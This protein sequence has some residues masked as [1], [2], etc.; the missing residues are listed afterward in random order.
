MPLQKPTEEATVKEPVKSS[1]MG[2]PV[3]LHIEPN[4]KKSYTLDRAVVN[5]PYVAELY[6]VF[7]KKFG[8]EKLELASGSFG[9]LVFN[10]TT[11]VLSGTPKTAE[12]LS[13][14][15]RVSTQPSET[16]SFTLEV[17]AR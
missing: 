11:G 3:S 4:S 2:S 12:N 1:T 6:N 17:A 13:F 5:Q 10:S 7:D 9:S 8:K 14:T 15:F 16:Q